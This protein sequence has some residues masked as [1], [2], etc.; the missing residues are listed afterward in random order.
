MATDVEAEQAKGKEQEAIQ[1]DASGLKGK[2]VMECA[3]D[4][5]ML[6]V[7]ELESAPLASLPPLESESDNDYIRGDDSSSDDDEETV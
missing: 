2:S 5:R 7:Y 3:Q 6:V 1:I 4:E